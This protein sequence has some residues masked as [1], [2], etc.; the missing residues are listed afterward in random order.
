MG[1]RSKHVY[2]ERIRCYESTYTGLDLFF[3]RMNYF[4]DTSPLIFVFSTSLDHTEAL[5]NVDDVIDTAAFH[6][7]LLRALIEVEETTLR[8]P[9]QEEEPA[10]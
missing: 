1:I 7:K 2:I 8:R 6:T 10:A 4:V 9:I 3:N 5:Q